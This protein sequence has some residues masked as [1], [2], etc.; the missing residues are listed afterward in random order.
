MAGLL[1]S[2]FAKTRVIVALRA[3][4]DE[5]GTHWGGPMACDVFVLCGYIA[6]ESL[7]DDTTD[8]SFVARWKNIMH[9]KTFHAEEMET[10]PQGPSVKL[11]LANIANSS[12]IIGIGGGINL[13]AY[14]RVLLPYILKHNQLD[15]PYYF[16]FSDVITEAIKRAEIF[17]G[18]D[19]DEPIGFV[20]AN[21]RWATYA[22]GFYNHLKADTETPDEVRAKMGA[23]AFKGIDGSIPLQAADHLAFETYHHMNDPPGTVRPAM[24]RLRDWPQNYGKY[25][26]EKDLIRYVELCKHEGIFS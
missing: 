15:D 18:E 17:L 14:R 19:K 25:Y 3:Y 9:G 6:P 1:H 10:N 12:G 11:Q 4:F 23:C 16:L 2:P 20:F 24:N 8:R 21:A 13:P 26:N 22:L 5:S 7:W